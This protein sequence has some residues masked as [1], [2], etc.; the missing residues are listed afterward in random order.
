M[1]TRNNRIVLVALIFAALACGM[2]GCTTTRTYT[3]E[4]ITGVPVEGGGTKDTLKIEST[5][6]AF[7]GMGGGYQRRPYTEGRVY[8]ISGVRYY[9]N[10]SRSCGPTL[11]ERIR[12]KK[13]CR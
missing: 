4:R 10:G 1:V 7:G 11:D 8:G 2:G 3:E 9:S 13:D 12:G 5:G 6:P